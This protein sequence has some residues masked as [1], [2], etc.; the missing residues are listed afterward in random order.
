[1]GKLLSP[2][3]GRYF[4]MSAGLGAPLPFHLRW[5]LP[6][7]AGKELR[8]W[9]IAG[10]GGWALFVLSVGTMGGWPAA[11]LVAVLPGPAVIFQFPR[12]VD[13]YALGIAAVTAAQ[14]VWWLQILLGVY[15]GSVSERAP[16]FA[17][18][19]AWS[20]WPL[21]GLIA[22]ALRYAFWRPGAEVPSL[23]GTYAANVL[24]KPWRIG[25][26]RDWHDLGLIAPWGGLCTAIAWL[27]AQMAVTLLVAYAQLLV[28]TD[29]SRLYQWAAPVLAISIAQHVDW[30]LCLLIALITWFNPWRGNGI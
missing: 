24:I 6:F 7:L 20:P 14:D 11:L 2:D 12:L 5:L 21:V 19:W 28:A 30:R 13:G 3:E 10:I 9:R 26:Q 15:A 16:L 8:A 1:M 27:D 4:H 23:A 29:R 17:A 22:P 25:L 18:L